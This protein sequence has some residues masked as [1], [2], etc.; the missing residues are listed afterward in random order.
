MMYSGYAAIRSK[1][2]KKIVLFSGRYDLSLYDGLELCIRGDGRPFIVNIQCPGLARKDD[3]WQTLMYT[4]GGVFWEN[5]ILPFSEFVLTHRG[6]LQDHQMNL[7]RQYLSTVGLMLADRTD[8]PFQLDIKYI[9]AVQTLT[10][11]ASI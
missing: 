8:G 10:K 1:P 2:L 5:I 3:L 4:R 6:Y 7:P 11:V 9:N